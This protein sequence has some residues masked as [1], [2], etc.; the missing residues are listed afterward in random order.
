MFDRFTDRARSIIEL[1]GDEA[2]RLGDSDVGTV[3]VLLGMIREHKGI[4]GHVLADAGLDAEKIDCHLAEYDTASATIDATLDQLAAAATEAA[5]WLGHRYPGTEHL[6]LGL[7]TLQDS[8]AV[9]LLRAIGI[10]PRRLCNDVLS[11][12]GH[13]DEDRWLQDH[14]SVT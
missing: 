8:D 14:P 2:T 10:A 1:A 11:I 12:L 6:L 4:A 13:F 9:H 7:C 5:E 3:H